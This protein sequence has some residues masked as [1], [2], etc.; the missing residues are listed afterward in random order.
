MS[1]ELRVLRAPAETFRQM[2]ASNEHGMWTLMRRPLLLVFAMGM[3]LSVASST[4]VSLR[5]V[6]DSMISFA[7]VP[8]IEILAVG[9]VYL[10][11]D[12]RV[13]FTRAVDLFFV[14]N[15]PWL[16]WI[17]G[18]CIWQAATSPTR[19]SQ[20]TALAL[21]ASLL[22]PAAWAAYIDL[23]Y[24]RTVITRGDRTAGFDVITTRL[25]GWLGVLGYFFG[26]AAWAQ[27]VAWLT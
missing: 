10:R 14:S 27:I 6:V 17:L 24:F 11:C 26:I 3:L 2:A 18:F 15:S 4:R 13:P 8:I 9:I 16:L 22:V 12:R 23:Q 5:V 25:V 20:T 19:M 21:V 7:F 1:P